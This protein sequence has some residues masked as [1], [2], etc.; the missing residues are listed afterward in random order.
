MKAL[1]IGILATVKTIDIP[2]T[3][4]LPNIQKRQSPK[5]KLKKS[6]KSK[7]NK[8]YKSTKPIKA[9]TSTIF[10]NKSNI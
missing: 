1:L 5:T 10:R 2:K 8:N 9:K 4:S 6:F 7:P 3:R